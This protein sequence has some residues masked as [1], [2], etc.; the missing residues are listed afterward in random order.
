VVYYKM[1]KSLFR[2]WAKRFLGMVEDTQVHDS[3]GNNLRDGKK[4][5]LRAQMIL[6]ETM[7]ESYNVMFMVEKRKNP[8][9]CV[10]QNHWR[11]SQNLNLTGLKG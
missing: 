3:T 10:A 6:R 1:D 2:S 9:R 11:R 7:L 8:S 4:K 5:L